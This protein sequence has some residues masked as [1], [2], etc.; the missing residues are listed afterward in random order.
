MFEILVFVK[1]KF[2]CPDTGGDDWELVQEEYDEAEQVPDIIERLLAD[3]PDDV[4]R[5]EINQQV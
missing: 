2:V 4:I 1:T 5:L 3:Y